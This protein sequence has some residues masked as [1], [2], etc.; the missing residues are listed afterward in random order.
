MYQGCSMV[1]LRKV[2][3]SSY[4]NHVN[5]NNSTTTGFSSCQVRGIK[6]SIQVPHCRAKIFQR[7]FA[8]TIAS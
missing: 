5:E 6:S 1:R 2:Y 7:K 8:R 3:R 4:N